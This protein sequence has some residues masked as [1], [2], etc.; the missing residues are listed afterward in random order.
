MEKGQQKRTV[1]RMLEAF[2]NKTPGEPDVAT[3]IEVIGSRLNT[4]ADS[5]CPVPLRL[6][7]SISEKMAFG[8]DKLPAKMQLLVK[9]KPIT[10][11]GT[12]YP[13][14]FLN[15]L[16]C[17]VDKTFDTQQSPCTFT[18][19]L[20][21]E[22]QQPIYRYQQNVNVDSFLATPMLQIDESSSLP[23]SLTYDDT[24][25]CAL[26]LMYSEG[27][28]GERY[29]VFKGLPASC[30]LEDAEFYAEQNLWVLPINTE[31]NKI[32]FSVSHL[33]H[34]LREI[35]CWAV[36]AD[37]ASQQC[38][39][40]FKTTVQIM[41]P[42]R[43]DY[44]NAFV[45]SANELRE[46]APCDIEISMMNLKHYDTLDSLLLNG[47]PKGAHCT[48]KN[49]SIE[50]EGEHLS[51][52]PGSML[53][54]VELT[55]TFAPHF[56]PKE[57]LVLELVYT[58]SNDGGTSTKRQ[59]LA[60]LQ[61]KGIAKP[62]TCQVHCENTHC[63]QGDTLTFEL[64]CQTTCQDDS[65]RLHSVVISPLE[66][67]QVEQF[68][69]EFDEN[70]SD[71]LSID[72]KKQQW[73]L[74][75]SCL[76]A[77]ELNI[78]CHLTP[79]HRSFYGDAV[80]LIDCVTQESDN[81]SEFCSL[82]TPCIARFEIEP[83]Q[84]APFTLN[85]PLHIKQDRK[86]KTI[87]IEGKP[88]QLV[89]VPYEV[90]DY[91]LNQD[92]KLTLQA[93]FQEG[94]EGY[95]VNTRNELN[96]TLTEVVL[97]N[98][99]HAY[100]VALP[101]SALAATSPTQ[102]NLTM[103][104]R[105]LLSGKQRTTTKTT[106]ISILPCVTKPQTKLACDKSI[107]SQEDTFTLNIDW[108]KSTS[109]TERIDWVELWLPKGITPVDLNMKKTAARVWRMN[110][111]KLNKE[112]KRL[113]LKCNVFTQLHGEL[114][115]KALVRITET[116]QAQ[117]TDLKKLSAIS[118]PTEVKL[119]VTPQQPAPPI[120]RMDS[121]VFYNRTLKKQKTIKYMKQA[122]SAQVSPPVKMVG[123]TKVA[124]PLQIEFDSTGPNDEVTLN[125][126]LINTALTEDLHL[127]KIE[128]NQEPVYLN[129]SATVNKDDLRNLFLLAPVGYCKDIPI[130][131]LASCTVRNKL[132]GIT[133][134]PKNSPLCQAVACVSLQ[135]V[136]IE[137]R[138]RVE[139][140]RAETDLFDPIE[141]KLLVSN[142]EALDAEHTFH[143]LLENDKG[144][145]VHLSSARNH[146]DPNRDWQSLLLDQNNIDIDFIPCPDNCTQSLTL[147]S[148]VTKADKLPSLAQFKR[149]YL[150]K[151]KLQLNLVKPSVNVT[152]SLKKISD[153]QDTCRYQLPFIPANAR[154]HPSVTRHVECLSSSFESGCKLVLLTTEQKQFDIPCLELREAISKNNFNLTLVYSYQYGLTR[155][156][157]EVHYEGDLDFT[158][159][160]ATSQIKAKTLR[161]RKLGEHDFTIHLDNLPS[162]AALSKITLGKVDGV[163]LNQDKVKEIPWCCAEEEDFFIV[164]LSERCPAK[165][166]IPIT[167][168]SQSFEE[169]LLPVV[170]SFTHEST[171]PFLKKSAAEQLFCSVPILVDETA[172]PQPP[173]FDCPPVVRLYG[174]SQ[175]NTLPA[176]GVIAAPDSS[177]AKLTVRLPSTSNDLLLEHPSCKKQQKQLTLST[178]QQLRELKLCYS[179]SS[180]SFIPYELII[181][182]TARSTLSDNALLSH[183]V[184]SISNIYLLPEVEKA[185]LSLTQQGELCCYHIE[186]NS[187]FT[188][189][190]SCEIQLG[191]D[192]N[193]RYTLINTSQH[194]IEVNTNRYQLEYSA[195]TSVSGTFSLPASSQNETVE[196]ILYVSTF[197]PELVDISPEHANTTTAALLTYARPVVPPVK[198]VSSEEEQ[199][200]EIPPAPIVSGTEKTRE[201]TISSPNS[202]KTTQQS[203][204]DE[205][206]E[207]TKVTL[208]PVKKTRK[209]SAAPSSSVTTT[210]QRPTSEE[211][212]TTKVTLSPIKKI[213]RKPAASAT[214]TTT[215]STEN[216]LPVTNEPAKKASDSRTHD[217]TSAITYHTPVE[218]RRK[219]ST[220]SSVVEC[221]AKEKVSETLPPSNKKETS[222]TILLIK[223]H[224][225]SSQ[226]KKTPTHTRET[227]SNSKAAKPLHQTEK[228]PLSPKIA[229]TVKLNS[230]PCTDE[231]IHCDPLDSIHLDIA[232]TDITLSD[233][234]MLKI[235]GLP[236]NC[237]CPNGTYHELQAG[238][239]QAKGYWLLSPLTKS[240]TI[241][242]SAKKQS[243]YVLLVQLVQ[244]NVVLTQQT[245]TF[246]THVKLLPVTP[247]LLLA[248]D[249]IE[250][251]QL[252][253]LF[254]EEI[255]TE[256]SYQQA[257]YTAYLIDVARSPALA[258]LDHHEM[259]YSQLNVILKSLLKEDVPFVL[260][261]HMIFD[262]DIM[263]F[264]LDPTLTTDSDYHFS[265]S[266]ENFYDIYPEINEDDTENIDLLFEQ[267]QQADSDHSGTHDNQV[268]LGDK[269]IQLDLTAFIN[270]LPADRHVN[271]YSVFLPEGA[272][273]C[274]KG[275]PALK[276]DNYYIDAEKGELATLT[277]NCHDIYGDNFT[278]V[279]SIGLLP[280]DSLADEL[281]WLEP[282]TIHCVLDEGIKSTTELNH[283]RI[284]T[285][286]PDNT[287]T[288]EDRYIDFTTVSEHL[289]HEMQAC[290][291]SLLED[292]PAIDN[293]SAPLD[294]LLNPEP[295]HSLDD[296]LTSKGDIIN[297]EFPKKRNHK[298]K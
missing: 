141:L 96:K 270:A 144:V 118:P 265:V 20:Y 2:A 228:K 154:V 247:L 274:E 259:D 126:E 83:M 153:L 225:T 95:F 105:N 207:T 283:A 201:K 215:A 183:S 128:S 88:W 35:E 193:E 199:D 192:I 131:L 30:S 103:E 219:R 245:R 94:E 87:H 202:D 82:V 75:V 149:D 114:A 257:N 268:H 226:A 190:Q 261:P 256:V 269:S 145:I 297:V 284:C 224:T 69:L 206:K 41:P 62:A 286:Q 197:I 77:R 150:H 253:T 6:T 38:S 46:G 107:I 217:K 251:S 165:L 287:L 8:C 71:K 175:N 80:F 187:R 229:I 240:I 151:A 194:W 32:T 158:L 48:A 173:E 64:V 137:P 180:L 123:K 140:V 252:P 291:D 124:Y 258:E 15:E 282:I 167:L 263:T 73:R 110:V 246:S 203:S 115:I 169:R 111:N 9:G 132:S 130:K 209:K 129:L 234:T 70:L 10:T 208:S 72:N 142:F 156:S 296:N 81:P 171:H 250:T 16:Q 162:E 108:T 221:N 11:N 76:D 235:F 148:L 139:V 231:K 36:N 147:Y 223:S 293:S 33:S 56:A 127:V 239:S 155:E 22:Q 60:P 51:I 222:N 255:A 277:I 204:T 40:P 214:S 213:R 220:A 186:V 181:E 109:P 273:I 4:R 280:V 47:L 44:V 74:D 168:L 133:L 86:E 50:S 102:I 189:L 119:T 218:P 198:T 23:V 243:Q 288:V 266:V 262:T 271:C 125:L 104:S 93:K 212:E 68:V 37:E 295:Y 264:Y 24:L 90:E 272:E 170:L 188:Q 13:I 121:L 138:C 66:G 31:D 12:L 26:T 25:T 112:I 281:T 244:E 294:M 53:Q 241:S 61:I 227:L 113:R 174:A 146:F 29:L 17:Q 100:L 39:A 248:G 191:N 14:N 3:D 238:A 178:P 92:N 161:Y 143:L 200:I 278:L 97:S 236:D 210:Q 57:A 249:I 182:A 116:N 52:T 292:D 67:I 195:Q 43:P 230:T 49:A 159:N 267:S 91:L 135:K 285:I 85:A 59:L 117:Q 233:N 232:L 19:T 237:D 18:L 160:L 28:I 289:S 196:L 152:G 5:T 65:D 84:A 89:K 242:L 205:K 176:M 27:H 136:S 54:P 254:I 99:K 276:D 211:K 21:D 42:L 45:T 179:Q 298:K 98:G 164:E 290:L 157:T 122:Q 55:V 184:S 1:K 260:N 185:Q 216:V 106:S 163:V 101:E 78:Q 79:K 7:G 166:E 120:L 279:L 34:D 177:L 58:I 172:I 63:T 134:T 275:I